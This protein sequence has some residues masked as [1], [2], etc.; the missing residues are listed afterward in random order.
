MFRFCKEKDNKEHPTIWVERPCDTFCCQEQ[1]QLS[2]AELNRVFH[3][4]KWSMIG[5]GLTGSVCDVARSKAAARTPSGTIRTIPFSPYPKDRPSKNHFTRLPGSWI[6]LTLVFGWDYH[7]APRLQK[8]IQ[9]RILPF[10]SPQGFLTFWDHFSRIL[11]GKTH[12]T[13]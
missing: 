9:V 10:H 8:P 12:I 2:V 11:S 7:K 1:L 6:S 5:T 4:P 3:F 13:I